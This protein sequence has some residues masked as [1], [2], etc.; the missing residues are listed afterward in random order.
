[1]DN[2]CFRGGLAASVAESERSHRFLGFRA[3]HRLTILRCVGKRAF[4]N[5]LIIL[6]YS[7]DPRKLGVVLLSLH[8]IYCHG[9]LTF[10]C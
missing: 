10:L 3:L 9:S 7:H 8:L 6:V 2:L 1:M 5:S 4:G